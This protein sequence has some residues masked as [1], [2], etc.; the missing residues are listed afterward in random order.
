MSG[1]KS[2]ESP[3]KS[4]LV[5]MAEYEHSE[6]TSFDS[7]QE[8]LKVDTWDSIY[9]QKSQKLHVCSKKIFPY[10]YFDNHLLYI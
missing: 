1:R 8:I 2:N 9:V 6:K 4:G 10:S 7:F 5:G 3:E